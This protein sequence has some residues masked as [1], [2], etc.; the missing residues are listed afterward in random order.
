MGLMPL[1]GFIVAAALASA[2]P[3]P[4]VPG[5]ETVVL[6]PDTQYYSQKFP[7]HFINQTQWIRQNVRDRH[8]RMVLQLGDV[9]NDNCPSEWSIARKCMEPL[10]GVVP[11]ALAM[12]NHDYGQ[13]G[14]CNR[15]R[16]FANDY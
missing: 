16:T 4:Y 7:Q 14:S 15:R 9:T 2:E 3:L 6:L 10:R 5:S 8:I 1:L 12:G 11:F 13:F